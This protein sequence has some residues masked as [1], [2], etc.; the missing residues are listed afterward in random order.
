MSKGIRQGDPLSLFLF[1]ISMEG[2]DIFM[3]T[4]CELHYFHGH[5]ILH[6]N[7]S[8][9][10]LIYVDDETLIREWSEINFVNLNRL[11]RCFYLVSGLNVNLY[12]IKVFGVGVDSTDVDGLASNLNCEPASFPFTYLGLLVGANMRRAKKWKL[13]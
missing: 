13:A 12:K 2:V 8:L 6:N 4:T 11:L 5:S 1:I 7:I 9:S 3:N 10:N